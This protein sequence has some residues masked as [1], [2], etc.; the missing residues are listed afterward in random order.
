MNPY[1]IVVALVAYFAAGLAGF[2]LGIDHQKAQEVDKT[3]LVS[4]AVDAAN[5]ASAA[6]LASLRPK[7]T[8][9]QN[10]VQREVQTHTIYTDC[11]LSPDGLLLANQ[12]LTG[13]TKPS[14][15]GELP[16]ADPAGK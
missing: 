15:G 13:G 6:V 16:K 1:L 9:I 5:A 2:R 3:E 8:T 10:E 12:A 14:G 4:E 7:Y 11:K